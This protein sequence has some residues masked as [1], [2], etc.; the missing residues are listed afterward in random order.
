MH[1][2]VREAESRGGQ[3]K[4]RLDHRSCQTTKARSDLEEIKA[5]SKDTRTTH[6]EEDREEPLC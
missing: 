6:Q 5:A 4:L 3:N 2:G 1:V